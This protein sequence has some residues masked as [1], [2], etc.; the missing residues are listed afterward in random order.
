MDKAALLEF[1]E[2]QINDSADLIKTGGDNTDLSAS[3]KLRFY[4]HLRTVLKGKR[5]AEAFGLLDG[6]NDT[7][8]Y[9]KILP[10]NKTFLS[11]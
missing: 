8:Q 5:D 3:G 2:K 6:I 4:M 1:V 9:L 11:D 10:A 7:L